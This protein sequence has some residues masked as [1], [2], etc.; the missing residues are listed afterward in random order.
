MALEVEGRRGAGH[1]AR[2]AEHLNHRNG[3]RERIRGTWAGAVDLR[4]PKL[5]KGSYFNI[6]LEPRRSAEKAPVAV[7]R[8]AY[9]QERL[10][11]E[12]KR[13]TNVAGCAG[14]RRL[15]RRPC[16][17]PDEAAVT[18]LLGAILAEQNDEWAVCRR[19]ITLET[20]A[21]IGHPQ[22]GPL[23]LAAR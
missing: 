15:R 6:F 3:H 11:K 18:C 1:G 23:T 7:I 12:I 17:L 21:Q 10:N 2:S 5:L 16:L 13:R 9:V 4:I 8:E 14:L 19:S 22:D 20:L